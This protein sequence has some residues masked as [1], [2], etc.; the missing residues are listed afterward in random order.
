[1]REILYFQLGNYSNYI[2]THFW[3]TQEA[4]LSQQSGDEGPVDD[5]VSL[6]ERQDPD[7]RFISMSFLNARA[8]KGRRILS[9]GPY[10][11]LERLDMLCVSVNF[12]W[13]CLG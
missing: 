9:E 1:M 2:G 3:N 13:T 5:Q 6:A 10:V 12:N 7:V 4:Y 8:V 11:W